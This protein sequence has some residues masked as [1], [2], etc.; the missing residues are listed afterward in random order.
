MPIY[1]YQCSSCQKVMEVMAKMSD[2]APTKCVNCGTEKQLQ[3]QIARTAFQLKGDGWYNSGYEGK[4]NR[5]SSAGS[6]SSASG[7]S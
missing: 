4:S 1:A 6:S 2:P 5:S 3:K 7:D